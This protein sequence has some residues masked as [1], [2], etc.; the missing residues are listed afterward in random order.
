MHLIEQVPQP[1]SEYRIIPLSRGLHAIVDAEDFDRVSAF[2]WYAAFVKNAASFSWYAVRTA[3]K[4]EPGPRRVYMHRFIANA[5][6]KVK[7]D[8]RNPSESLDNRKSNL[9][10]ASTSQNGFNRGV[11]K[12]NKAGL[13]GVGVRKDRRGYRSRITFQGEELHLGT[14]DTKEEAHAVYVAKAKELH[15]EFART[16]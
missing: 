16:E 3:R 1:Q 15:G 4:N 12:N 14:F 11:Q 5:T 13:K 9:R 10:D 2:P 6:G 8:H 7:I